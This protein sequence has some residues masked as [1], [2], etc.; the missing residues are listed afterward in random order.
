MTPLLCA[1]WGTTS[2]RVRL[3]DAD[4]EAVLAETSND[5]GVAQTYASWMSGGGL[6]I[7]FFQHILADSIRALG[8]SLEGVPLVLSGM[9]SSNIGLQ[10]L[11]Y[12]ELPFR[13]DGADLCTLGLEASAVFPHSILLVSGVRALRD[14]MRGEETQLAGC[15]P[16]EGTHRFIFPGTHSKHVFVRDGLSTG[17]QT[18]MTGE[19]F[20]LLSKHSLLARSVEEN[21]SAYPGAFA[22]GVTDSIAGDI[23]QNAFLVRTNQLFGRLS[24]VENYHYLSGLV[25]GSE[26]K[27]LLLDETAVTIV[28]N[29]AQR[30]QY[31]EAARV[32]GLRDVR[33]HDAA[34]AGVR[35]QCAL[36]RLGLGPSPGPGLGG[37]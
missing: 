15:P 33:S 31:L 18:Y 24:P 19:F 10:E 36:F 4:T 5:S 28:G 6:R 9:A 23:L 26:L 13:A 14:V 30:A 25:I 2:L 21:T 22:L 34:V 27:G 3:V 35:G 20:A 1:D 11:P 7:P 29:A 32:L 17:F 37:A 12:K 16:V 8:S